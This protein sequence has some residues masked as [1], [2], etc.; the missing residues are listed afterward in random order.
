MAARSVSATDNP[1][2]ATAEPPASD[3]HAPAPDRE[4]RGALE[5]FV[6]WF[7]PEENPTGAVYGL[8]AIAALVAVENERQDSLLDTEVAGIIAACLYWLLHSYAGVLGRRLSARE[9]LTARTLLTALGDDLQLLRGAA[10]PLLALAVA[11]AAGA[12]RSTAVAAA[13][14]S[15]IVCIVALEVIAGVRARSTP[16]ELVLEAT[17]G[18]AMGLAILA[19]RVVLH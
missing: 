13:L 6:E 2:I 18:L 1:P 9:H 16:R 5:R 3:E 17:V 4:P 19:M 10:I 14:W 11:W 7:V 8:I 12:S 15:A